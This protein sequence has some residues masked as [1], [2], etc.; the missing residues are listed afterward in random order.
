MPVSTLDAEIVF[1]SGRKSKGVPHRDCHP[2]EHYDVRVPEKM[3]KDRKCW[4]ADGSVASDVV[5]AAAA[6]AWAERV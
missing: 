2:L 6:A 5:A 1:F 3:L 4:V